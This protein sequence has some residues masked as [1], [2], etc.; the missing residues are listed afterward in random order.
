MSRL[1]AIGGGNF[2]RIGHHG[3][4]WHASCFIPA[5][6]TNGGLSSTRF[7][8]TT[9]VSGR[10]QY[11]GTDIH[12]RSNPRR[13]KTRRDKTRRLAYQI[14]S[15]ALVVVGPASL[16]C[17]RGVA[18]PHEQQNKHAGMIKPML[19]P[20]EQ[21]S[22]LCIG[23]YCRYYRAGPM[24]G[25]TTSSAPTRVNAG[26]HGSILPRLFCAFGLLSI[27]APFASARQ[28]LG[29]ALAGLFFFFFGFCHASMGLVARGLRCQNG[30]LGQEL[31]TNYQ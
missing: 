5:S 16:S 27:N 17:G 25:T 18:G 23:R 19:C 11:M 3:L 1:L 9:G 12:R 21:D 7:I 8:E 22:T 2:G 30:S 28:V 26:C 29:V 14:D 10:P 15:S 24:S 31:P 20:D 6:Q 4:G 13:I